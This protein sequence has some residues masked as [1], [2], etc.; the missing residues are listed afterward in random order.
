VTPKGHIEVGLVPVDFMTFGQISNKTEIANS[1]VFSLE[2]ARVAAV[3]YW[4]QFGRNPPADLHDSI[5][6]NL[7]KFGESR[8]PTAP[9]RAAGRGIS[10]RMGRWVDQGA[11][12][13]AA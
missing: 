6:R 12:G 8:D 11:N 9:A 1:E 5:E 4:Q 2:F 3:A 7:L 13:S 10:S